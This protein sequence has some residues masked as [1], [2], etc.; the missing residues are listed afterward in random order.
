MRTYARD[1]RLREGQ[2]R[3][4]YTTHRFGSVK[5]RYRNAISTRRGCLRYIMVMPSQWAASSRPTVSMPWATT[6]MLSRPRKG[7]NTWET[8][9]AS[10]PSLPREHNRVF[11]DVD[12]DPA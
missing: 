3:H 7:A 10:A 12:P 8:A 6:H 11:R 9:P 2:H 1:A 4:R 5:S